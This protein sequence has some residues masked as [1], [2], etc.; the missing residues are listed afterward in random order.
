MQPWTLMAPSQLVQFPAAALI[1]RKALIRTGDV[2]A[3]VNLNTNDLL[4]LKGTPLP[5]DA[6]LDE[7]RLKDVPI[8]GEIKPGQRID[9]LIHYAGR[10][11]VSFTGSPS[12]SEIKDLGPMIDRT[13]QEVTSSTRELSVN[14]K[15]G[16]L[17]INAP[18]AQGVSGNFRSSRVHLE[19]TVFTSDSDNIHMIVV[20]LDGEKLSNSKRMLLQVMSEERPTGFRVEETSGGI[21][22]I[23]DIG[24][25]PW[26]VKNITGSV[27]FRSPVQIQPLDFN[28]YPAGEKKTRAEIQL[29][30]ATIYYLLTR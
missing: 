20:S 24:R 14:Y 12:K 10:A 7:L 4:N 5:Q 28:G 16:L 25:D 8:R 13:K 17:T 18:Q 9:P 6:N 2:L 23:A 29:A 21:L 1:Y 22:K 19:D 26:Q 30:P 11:E 15:D 3:K 27:A